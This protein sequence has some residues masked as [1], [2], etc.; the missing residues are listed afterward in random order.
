MTLEE[1]QTNLTNINNNNIQKYGTLW[2]NIKNIIDNQCTEL[3]TQL[4]SQN[5]GYSESL[6]RKNRIREEEQTQLID[7]TDTYNYVYYYLWLMISNYGINV[8]IKP[9]VNNIVN[10][11]IKQNL[12][13]QQ[14][15]FTYENQLNNDTLDKDIK[16]HFEQNWDKIKD[17][18]VKTLKQVVKDNGTPTLKILNE[19]LSYSGRRFLEDE[20]NTETF[21]NYTAIKQYVL[22]YLN[23]LEQFADN[24][25][26]GNAEF[27]KLF[28]SIS[29][30]VVN[31][32][33]NNN[34]FN[35][36]LNGNTSDISQE[37]NEI[38]DDTKNITKPEIKTL[39]EY[40]LIPYFKDLLSKYT[41]SNADKI[42]EYFD[43][44][45]NLS[46]S[47]N[48]LSKSRLG[49][50]ESL[51]KKFCRLKEEEQTQNN[52]QTTQSN[53]FN[54]IFKNIEDMKKKAESYN[55]TEHVLEVWIKS[56]KESTNENIKDFWNDV[57]NSIASD[58]DQTFTVNQTNAKNGTDNAFSNFLD[59]MFEMYKFHCVT[60]DGS[61]LYNNGDNGTKCSFLITV[62]KEENK[63][64]N[65]WN[66]LGNL[67]L[68][69]AGVKVNSEWK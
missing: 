37:G 53:T 47:F 31:K 34:D 63:S 9:Y 52:N 24:D 21:D 55:S 10:N 25:S 3:C 45:C 62:I 2:N 58:F 18:I 33:R 26:K 43:D 11:L 17:V 61:F 56:D 23:S 64:S 39:V 5:A 22:N 30:E 50:K 28:D 1:I 60:N 41:K 38:L 19:M 29:D 40:K 14:D 7:Y 36:L 15:I 35:N 68:S 20:Q 46:I 48:E 44:G 69:P 32:L 16:P 67:K 59:N 51:I 57:Y 12:V 6:K 13:Q 65:F 42:K 49:I 27:T 54:D 66:K 8:N 4:S